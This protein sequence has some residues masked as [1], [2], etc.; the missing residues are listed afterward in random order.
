[1]LS[2]QVFDESEAS[3]SLGQSGLLIV[4]DFHNV[5]SCA[6]DHQNVRGV[7]VFRRFTVVFESERLLLPRVGMC[8]GYQ[9]L[10]RFEFILGFRVA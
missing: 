5:L 7:A 2:E 3:Q 8:C 6:P 4:L 1:M 9:D 10:K